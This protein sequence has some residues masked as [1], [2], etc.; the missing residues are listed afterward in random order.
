MVWS[1]SLQYFNVLV[2]TRS[3]WGICS[4]NFHSLSVAQHESPVI[5]G[6]GEYSRISLHDNVIQMNLLAMQTEDKQ[7]INTVYNTPRRKYP[8]A[9]GR[10]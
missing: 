2:Q 6:D 3:Q 7:A 8:V 10:T 5:N 1:A 9:V 4:R